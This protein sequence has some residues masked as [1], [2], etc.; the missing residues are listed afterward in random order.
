MANKISNVSYDQIP[1]VVKNH[2]DTNPEHWAI[3]I[4]LFKILKDKTQCIYSTE[5]LA[6]DCRMTLRTTER[7]LSELKK[8]MLI[9][10]IGTS[11]NRRI[12]L[13][14]LFT[15]PAIVADKN[16]TPPPKETFQPA[17]TDSS[18]RHSGGYNKPYNKPS[19]NE[20]LSAHAT[21]TSKDLLLKSEYNNDCKTLREL[22]LD[23]LIKDYEI[24]LSE[25]KISN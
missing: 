17:K 21:S 8:M 24:W 5:K 10:T 4:V 13:G 14:L 6:L 11:Y 20:D 9:T 15:T 2:P 1:H 16:S 25:K 22:N 7:R 12:S 23:H 3:M 19:T 18:A